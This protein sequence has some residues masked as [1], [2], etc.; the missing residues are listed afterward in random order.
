MKKKLTLVSC[1]IVVF[2]FYL[3]NEKEVK[4]FFINS[5]KINHLY[6]FKK[7]PID[8]DDYKV[9]VG[10]SNDKKYGKMASVVERWNKYSEN[11]AT[12]VELQSIFFTKSDITLYSTFLNSENNLLEYELVTIINKSG[13]YRFYEEE[14]KNKE[15]E[16]ATYLEEQLLFE[17]EGITY[18]LS[19]VQESVN[20][21]IELYGADNL[22]DMFF[23]NNFEK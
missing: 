14:Y 5:E 3:F 8:F 1:I 10:Y 21:P 13:Y 11:I 4:T 18:S 20:K 6:S 22:I 2:F 23:T 9:F 19:V 17:L 16:N 12:N 15:L 7:L